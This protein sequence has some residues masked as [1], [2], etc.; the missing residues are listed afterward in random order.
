MRTEFRRAAEA[1]FGLE[2]PEVE[3]VADESVGGCIR[4]GVRQPA[5]AEDVRR[6]AIGGEEQRLR[7]AAE[8]VQRVRAAPLVRLAKVVFDPGVEERRLVAHAE[9]PA[10]P[11]ALE[12]VEVDLGRRSELQG[13]DPIGAAH[14]AVIPGA[15]DE[16]V[17]APGLLA[18]MLVVATM[19]GEGAGQAGVIHAG[20]R[21]HRDVEPAQRLR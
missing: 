10:V 12:R 7:C 2:R 15:D 16:V 18:A 21:Q 19:V 13:I 11:P 6:M 14:P 20:Q 4:G 5:G 8:R 1:A 3:R 17:L 9:H